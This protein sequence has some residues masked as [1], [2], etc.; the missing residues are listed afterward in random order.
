MSYICVK[1][2]WLHMQN[3]EDK[4]ICMNAVLELYLILIKLIVVRVWKMLTIYF[5]N[6]IIIVL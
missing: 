6:L 5:L 1:Q 3:Y 2:E 4:E